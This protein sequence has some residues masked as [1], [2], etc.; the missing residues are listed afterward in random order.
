MNTRFC[1]L[2]FI[3]PDEFCLGGQWNGGSSGWLGCIRVVYL[4]KDRGL[5][6]KHFHKATYCSLILG[7]LFNAPKSQFFNL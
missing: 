3:F 5:E 6:V 1:L 2:V 7:K 4:F